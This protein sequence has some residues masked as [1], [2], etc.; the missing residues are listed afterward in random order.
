VVVSIDGL[1]VK[2][3]ETNMSGVG[4]SME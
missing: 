2:E 3:D 1:L 4:A